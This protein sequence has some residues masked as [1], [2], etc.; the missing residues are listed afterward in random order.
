MEKVVF[1][2]VS[3]P[4]PYTELMQIGAVQTEQRIAEGRE[5]LRSPSV[6]ET[7][8]GLRRKAVYLHMGT[9]A[10]EVTILQ[11]Y[12]GTSTILPI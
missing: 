4:D 11:K 6:V 10:R 5:A 3:E 8:L 7:A 12:F 9:Y 2:S 1:E